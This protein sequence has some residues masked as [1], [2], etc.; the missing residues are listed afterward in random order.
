MAKK[1]TIPPLQKARCA[2]T[3]G[4]MHAHGHE[5]PVAADATPAAPAGAPPHAGPRLRSG[6]MGPLWVARAAAAECR[7]IRGCTCACGILERQQKVGSPFELFAMVT[8]AALAL[9]TLVLY[10]TAVLLSVMDLEGYRV[11]E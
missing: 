9:Y 6:V 4:H 10:I 1:I 5:L 2:C 8:S 3:C 11:T 7:S